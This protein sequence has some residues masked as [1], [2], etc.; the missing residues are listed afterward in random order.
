MICGNCPYYHYEVGMEDADEY[1]DV[2]G[3]DFDSEKHSRKSEDGCRYNMKTL[4]KW[5][6]KRDEAFIKG[7]S[8]V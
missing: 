7:I 5:K 4:K 3:G 2:F 6:Q 8:D 1:C